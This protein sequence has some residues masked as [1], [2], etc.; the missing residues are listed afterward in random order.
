M[1]S[2]GVTEKIINNFLIFNFIKFYFKETL[3]GNPLVSRHTHTLYFDIDRNDLY[4][5]IANTPHEYKDA[6]GSR[7]WIC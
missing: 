1:S 5:I 4:K 7:W 2:M 3:Q 6:N